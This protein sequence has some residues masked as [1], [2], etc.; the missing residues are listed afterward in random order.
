ME[1]EKEIPEEK[2]GTEGF[3]DNPENICRLIDLIFLCEE[4]NEKLPR[5]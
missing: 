3:W 2:T 4:Q 5:S 1:Q